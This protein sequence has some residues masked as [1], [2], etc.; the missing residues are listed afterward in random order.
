MTTPKNYRICFDYSAETP[1]K[2][3]I[4]MLGIIED[5]NY[6][7]TGEEHKL[8]RSLAQ[9]DEEARKSMAELLR[10]LGKG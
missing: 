5:P 6:E 1:T 4:Y 2:A 10:R 9:I 3:L 7:E 8:T